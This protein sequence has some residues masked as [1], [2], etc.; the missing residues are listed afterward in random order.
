MRWNCRRSF[1]KNHRNCSLRISTKGRLIRTFNSYSFNFK[2]W[3]CN[4]RTGYC[5]CWAPC[6]GGDQ[7]LWFLKIDLLRF[8]LISF[9]SIKHLIFEIRLARSTIAN[10]CPI[11][12]HFNALDFN[13]CRSEE[14]ISFFWRSVYHH[15]HPDV[16]KPLLV[17]GYKSMKIFYSLFSLEGSY[18]TDL[19]CVNCDKCQ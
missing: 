18:V 19:I 16:N 5:P 7:F 12:I 3:L 14:V 17:L 6:P 11:M 15:N 1:F 13:E 9:D 4:R 8:H 2:G 10:V